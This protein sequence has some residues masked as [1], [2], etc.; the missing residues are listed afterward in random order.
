VAAVAVGL[1][2]AGCGS[3]SPTVAHVSSAQITRAADVSSSAVG[4]RTVM[5]I[6]ESIAKLGKITAHATGSFQGSS[7]SLSM[8]LDLPGAA[9][10][11]GPLGFQMVVSGKTIYLKLPSTLASD[12][13]LPSAKPWLELDLATVG[14]SAGVPG[15]SSL[16]GNSQQLSD[17]G[18]LLDYLRATASGSV[19]DLGQARVDGFQTTRYHAQ[20]DLSKLADAVPAAERPALQQTLSAL[21]QHTSLARMPIDVWIDSSHHVRRFTLVERLTTSGK[22]STVDIQAD[23]PDYGP[24]SP[25]TIPPASQVTNASKLLQGLS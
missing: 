22:T 11:L 19:A 24:Q 8:T 15:L 25:P 2:A 5:T 18:E 17:P 20:L 16:L 14:K 6:N 12:L 10:A 4:Y 1:L 21:K 9:A 7:G 13:S 3:S 23:F